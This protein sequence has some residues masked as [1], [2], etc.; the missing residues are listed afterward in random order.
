MT[1][2]ACIYSIL[3]QFVFCFSI[4]LLLSTPYAWVVSVRFVILC[5]KVEIVCLYST[6]VERCVRLCRTESV[7]AIFDKKSNIACRSMQ[8]KHVVVEGVD[9]V[10]IY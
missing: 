5:V 4:L 2:I 8:S 3:L 10:K 1:S 9:R 7:F 6:G